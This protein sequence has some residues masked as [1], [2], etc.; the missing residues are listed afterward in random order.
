MG[1][2]AVCVAGGVQTAVRD[3][4]SLVGGSRRAAGIG[5]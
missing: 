2:G 3:C 1:R 5:Q 4:L